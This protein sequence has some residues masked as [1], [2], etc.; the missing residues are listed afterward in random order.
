MMCVERRFFLA[1]FSKAVNE[2]NKELKSFLFKNMYRHRK[3]RSMETKAKLYLTEIFRAYFKSPK[4][5]PEKVLLNDKFGS[6]ERR[7]CDYISG[8][9]DRY[10]ISE[11]NKFLFR[12]KKVKQ[13]TMP[14]TSPTIFS[15][16]L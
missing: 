2:K 10:A 14:S 8:M 3:V 5:I 9:T 7:V 13:V 1:G 16:R 6:V 12:M 15:K 4:L 11:F